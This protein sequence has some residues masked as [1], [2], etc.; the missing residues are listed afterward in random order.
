MVTPQPSKTFCNYLSLHLKC[1]KVQRHTMEVVPS[2]FS[3]GSRMKG[4][5]EQLFNNNVDNI[6]MFIKMFI[7]LCGHSVITL[8]VKLVK[9]TVDLDLQ[10]NK[11]SC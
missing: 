8:P 7:H 10:R 6:C 4:E 2:S 3:E 1:L 9:Y 11:R 5:E